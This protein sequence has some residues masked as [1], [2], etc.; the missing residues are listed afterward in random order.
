MTVMVIAELLV[1]SCVATPTPATPTNTPTNTPIAT[2]THTPTAT[3]TN[4][5]TATS[6][7]GAPLK[8]DM[9]AIFPPGAGRD[10]VFENCVSSCHNFFP[11]LQQKTPG[12]W[13][14][15][16]LGNHRNRVRRLSDAEYALLIAYLVA[17][18]NPEKPLPELPPELT[19]GVRTWS[20]Y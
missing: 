5:P 12:A 8:L 7:S 1:V 14:M 9:N 15:T 10:L 13:K 4:T 16:L 17:N 2:P 19:V 6:A 20:A 18:F 3:P 11:L